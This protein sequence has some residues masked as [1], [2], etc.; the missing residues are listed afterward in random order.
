[1]SERFTFH[2]TALD[3]AVIAERHPRRDDRGYLERIFAPEEFTKITLGRTIQQINHTLTRQAGAA[4]GLH[5]QHPPYAEAKLVSCLRGQV[6]DVAVDLR[7]GSPTFLQWHGEILSDSNFRSFLIPEGFAHGFQTLSDDCE[8][9][10]LHSASYNKDAEG[11]LHPEEPRIGIR[12][13]REITELSARDTFHPR[14]DADYPGVI[15]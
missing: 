9:L 13:P 14:L 7:A 8:L 4:R 11:G 10:Y 12:W 6:F 15:L 3:G 1:M 5:F 2:P